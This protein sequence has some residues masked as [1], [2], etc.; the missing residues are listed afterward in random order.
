MRREAILNP[1]FG[2][3]AVL[4]KDKMFYA[5]DVYVLNITIDDFTTE[6]DTGENGISLAKLTN[7]FRD[8][9]AKC[10]FAELVYVKPLSDETYEYNAKDGKWYLVAQGPGYA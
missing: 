3:A 1:R 9:L 4:R 7:Q 2:V 6:I 5:G 10:Q 8:K